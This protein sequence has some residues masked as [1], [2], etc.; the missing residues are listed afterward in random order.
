MHH[1][2]MRAL[3]LTP[4]VLTVI[5]GY[6]LHTDLVVA[7]G[8]SAGCTVGAVVFLVPLTIFYKPASATYKV[9]LVTNVRRLPLD[10]S[11]LPLQQQVCFALC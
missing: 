6:S 2:A 9:C 8:L 11:H 4:V 3:L 1:P 5:S 10:G 7:A